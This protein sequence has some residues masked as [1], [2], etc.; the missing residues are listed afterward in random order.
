MGLII[1]A[2]LYIWAM[3]RLHR[4]GRRCAALTRL[5]GLANHV[6]GP[7]RRPGE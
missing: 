1:F 6:H 3:R 4:Q 2:V 7:Y 5:G